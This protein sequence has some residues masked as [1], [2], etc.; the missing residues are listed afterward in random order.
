LYLA[1]KTSD[2][3]IASADIIPSDF[4]QNL[5]KLI[6]EFTQNKKDYQTELNDLQ[7]QEVPEYFYQAKI[8]LTSVL[9]AYLDY[10]TSVIKG[11]KTKNTFYFDV[12]QFVRQMDDGV[13]KFTSQLGIIEKKG[14]F[15]Q[16]SEELS[17]KQTE[18]EKQIQD[19]KNQYKI[20]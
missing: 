1:E 6:E 11:L 5:T 12:D 9:E 4:N 2:D 13:S 7:A 19:L 17:K 16:K 20:K 8:S 10:L 3:L 18:I 14:N 15:A